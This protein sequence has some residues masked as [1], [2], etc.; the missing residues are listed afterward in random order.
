MAKR[1]K[2]SSWLPWLLILGVAGVAGFLFW[3]K[4]ERAK[5][6]AANAVIERCYE[7]RAGETIRYSFKGEDMVAF[8]IR[9][10]GDGMFSPQVVPFDSGEFTADSAG[11]YCLRFTNAL[12]QPQK[13]TYSVQR[14]R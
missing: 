2:K 1:K 4:L 7:L 13:I 11:E 9:R 5:T 14:Q 8:D 3:N 10:G 6:V 12:N